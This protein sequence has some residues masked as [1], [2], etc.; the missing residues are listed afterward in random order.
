MI[1]VITSPE[2]GFGA[3]TFQVDP[4]QAGLVTTT[5]DPSNRVLAP[6]QNNENVD[7]HSANQPPYAEYGVFSLAL[8]GLVVIYQT[9]PPVK[10]FLEKHL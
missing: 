10:R 1:N 8:T 2:D 9:A 5:T 7:Y 4:S 6:I 3:I